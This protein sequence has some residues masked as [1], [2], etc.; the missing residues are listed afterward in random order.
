MNKIEEKFYGVTK[1]HFPSST[2]VEYNNTTET[3][4]VFFKAGNNEFRET[5]TKTMGLLRLYVLIGDEKFETFM[6][7]VEDLHK[8]FTL[9]GESHNMDVKFMFV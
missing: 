8:V 3:L 9:G 7:D 2:K 4:Y 5:E 6:S 1:G